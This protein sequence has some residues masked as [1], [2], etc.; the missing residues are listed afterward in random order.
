MQV[1]APH[2]SILLI[3]SMLQERAMRL[4]PYR[5]HDGLLSVDF[6]RDNAVARFFRRHC[7]CFNTDRGVK[8]QHSAPHRSMFDQGMLARHSQMTCSG[9]ETVA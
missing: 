7:G 4:G 8:Q 3:V 6:S 2:R 5:P 1:K 9:F